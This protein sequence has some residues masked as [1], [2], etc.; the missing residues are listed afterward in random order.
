LSAVPGD[1]VTIDLGTTKTVSGI[2]IQGRSAGTQ[3]FGT[4]PRSF[5]HYCCRFFFSQPNSKFDRFID[6]PDSEAY[7]QNSISYADSSATVTIMEWVTGFAVSY[8]SDGVT[9]SQTIRGQNLEVVFD[10]NTVWIH[11][12]LF[13][14]FFFLKIIFTFHFW[15]QKMNAKSKC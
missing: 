12:F 6:F 7:P 4:M 3:S 2:G 10:G 15:F 8:S 9:F 13:F 5:F 1:F 11:S 14:S